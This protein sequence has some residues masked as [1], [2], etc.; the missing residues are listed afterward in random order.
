MAT[1]EQPTTVP[2]RAAEASFAAEI[3]RPRQIVDRAVIR[4][5]VFVAAVVFAVCLAWMPR[6][7]D[8]LDPLTGDEPFY[9]MTSISLIKDGDLNELNNFQQ[10]D[11]KRFYPPLGPTA[12]GWPAYPDPLPPHQSHTSR[13]GLYSKHGLGM[14]V[15]VALPFEL[16]GRP[17]T[18]VVLATIAAAMAA[19]MVLLARMFTTSDALA[20]AVA[21]IL[22]LTNPL[23]SFS[24]LIFPE[25]TA[26][27]CILYAMRRLLAG[28]NRAWQW[29]LVGACAAALPWL[30]YRL[31]PISVVIAVLVVMRH[32]RTMHATDILAALA[33]PVPSAIA[34]FSWHYYLY[35]SPV[36]PSEDHAGFSGVAGTI[37][38]FVGTFLDQ[39]WGAFIHSPLLLLA[40]ASFCPFFIWRRRDALSLAA[41]VVPYLLL[42]ANYN[43]WWGEWNPPARY[44]ADIVP[45]AAAPLAW[46][47]GMLASR[48]RWPV[49][50]A[51]SLPSLAIMTT[52]VLDP[53]RMY[54][55]PDGTSNLLEM[56]DRWLHLHLS[57]GIPSFV[58]Y[59]ASPVGQR[60]V[61]GVLGACLVMACA[62]LAMQQVKARDEY[63]P[64]APGQPPAEMPPAV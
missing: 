51:F 55:H 29:L 50:A 13:P 14:A 54:N 15:L 32:R 18:L 3:G 12:D 37:N 17:L 46:W 20:G 24:L 34:L 53:Q 49:L 19:N 39:Q 41:V 31:A 8:R 21:L 2:S 63:V 26:G 27:L 25:M 16:G 30:H 9:V 58:F 7:L 62:L 48:W 47:L 6:V 64:A 56:W 38:G 22:A 1:V 43:V 11:F 40:A 36:P 45:L 5:A 57:Q 52:F 59:S 23:L 28:S 44:L 60:Q 35:D 42:V 10:G 4:H 61:F 33:M